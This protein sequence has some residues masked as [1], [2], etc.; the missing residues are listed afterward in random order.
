M[1]LA[2]VCQHLFEGP[3]TRLLEQDLVARFLRHFPQRRAFDVDPTI[4]MR[5]LALVP[6]DVREHV[7]D[8][9]LP[10]HARLRHLAWAQTLQE[11][12]ELLTRRS[13]S[14]N[15]FRTFHWLR[16]SAP[17]NERPLW[18]KDVAF[19]IITVAD[20]VSLRN[21]GS[22]LETAW[23][24]GC[25]VRQGRGHGERARVGQALFHD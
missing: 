23:M 18:L 5:F 7:F 15:Q 1:C 4:E 21:V 19:G 10:G 9:P 14:V 2:E 25:H 11:S 12:L 13:N 16:T 6:C 3:T 17:R 24:V 22:V 8:G 20:L